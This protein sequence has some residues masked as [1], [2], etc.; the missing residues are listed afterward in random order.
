[1][2]KHI[3][4]ERSWFYIFRISI[5]VLT[6]SELSLCWSGI[7][8]VRLSS[9][10]SSHWLSRLTETES[11]LYIDV[12]NYDR[13][14]QACKNPAKRY[15]VSDLH[16]SLPGF[17]RIIRWYYVSCGVPMHDDYFFWSNSDNTWMFRCGTISWSHVS[18]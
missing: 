2:R 18:D 1:M 13:F 16:P 7:F 5:E 6:I 8:Q 12:Y 15:V 10:S 3:V 9:T 4:E 17:Q 11:Q 14:Q